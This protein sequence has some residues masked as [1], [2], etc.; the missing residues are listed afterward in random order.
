LK[1]GG[2]EIAKKQEIGRGLRLPVDTNG[3]RCTDSAVNELTVI[4]NDNFAHF[5]DNLQK[6][7]ND[8]MNFKKDEVTPEILSV[9][10]KNAGIPSDKINPQLIEKLKEE[11]FVAGIIDG[12]DML[13]KEAR[14]IEERA[15]FQ[16][17][18]LC[19]YTAQIIKAFKDCMHEKGSARIE[20][21]NGDNEQIENCVHT[22][23][24]EDD[25]FKFFKSLSEK[26]SKRTIYRLDL[27]KERFISESIEEVN[28]LLFYRTVKSVYEIT[29]AGVQAEDS[30]RIGIGE[31]KTR[32]VDNN[33]TESIVQKSDFE[34]ANA[35]MYHTNLPRFAIFR[36]M[37]GIEK[38]ILLSN[39]DV[40][41][42]VI[43]RLRLR[44]NDAKAAAINSYE[45]I[46]GY[47][48]DDKVIFEADVIEETMFETEEKV[49]KKK[50][51]KSKESERKAVNKYYRLDSD[52]EYDFAENLDDDPNVLL[53][54]KMK[55]GGF[56]IDTPYGDY[57]PDWAIVYKGTD[58]SVKLY[59]I[60]ETKYG[61][62]WRDLSDVEQCK[63]KCGRLHFKAIDEASSD[64][65]RFNWV[66]S[67]Q[68][69]KEMAEG[70]QKSHD[71]Q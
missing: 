37:A 28:E 19:E 60:I 33:T 31:A 17:P 1:H 27:N 59:F 29:T 9:T 39:Q 45:I 14:A 16:D 10:L 71:K 15:D 65:V 35:I 36:I 23:V 42:L 69:F 32:T 47:E 58:G 24:S 61:K 57:S 2:S 46:A 54:T 4:A 70:M 13:T 5:A 53:Y 66:S 6:D 34:I 38:K 51:Y 68:T 52:G 55:K 62:E 7:F 20:I 30:G 48:F 40:L 67:Y 41:D 43:K 8:S 63:I 22:Y 44:L 26:L 25:F 3:V 64:V 56:V 21:R 11:L 50:V 49:Y 12:K 18:I